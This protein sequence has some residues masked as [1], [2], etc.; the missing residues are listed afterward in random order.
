MTTY[1]ETFVTLTDEDGEEHTFSAFQLKTVRGKKGRTT[2]TYLDVDQVIRATIP[3]T[4]EQV[5]K[6]VLDKMV[7]WG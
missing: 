3:Q 5:R 4:A 6:E 7:E 2:I 1:K